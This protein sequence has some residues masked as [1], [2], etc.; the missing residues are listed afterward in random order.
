MTS[1][2][3]ADLLITSSER[4]S[5]SVCTEPS[6]AS[7]MPSTPWS[8][9]R[10]SWLMFARNSPLALALASAADLAFV[11]SISAARL[12][13]STRYAASPLSHASRMP[14]APPTNTTLSRLVTCDR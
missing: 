14:I 8:G 5:A 9:V 1:S 13:R 2:D 4:R 3:D 10:I 11:S 6:I 12:E 7:L